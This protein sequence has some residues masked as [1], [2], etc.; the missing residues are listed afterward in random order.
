MNF[1]LKSAW[2]SKEYCFTH[3]ILRLKAKLVIFTQQWNQN[4]NLRSS[5]VQQGEPLPQILFRENRWSQLINCITCWLE[6][7][8]TS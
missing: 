6:W 4:G 1:A 7:L 5:E 3:M 2:I 8:Q